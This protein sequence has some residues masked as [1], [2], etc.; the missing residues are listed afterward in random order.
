MGGASIEI[1]ERET[2]STLAAES[3]P[4]F[5][6]QSEWAGR[7]NPNQVFPCLFM[8]LPPRA[9]PKRLSLYRKNLTHWRE[10][11]RSADETL[12]VLGL[13]LLAGVISTTFAADE[14]EQQQKVPRAR[15]RITFPLSLSANANPVFH[16]FS[17]YSQRSMIASNTI[18]IPK[19]KVHIVKEKAYIGWLNNQSLFCRRIAVSSCDAASDTIGK[20]SSGDILQHKPISGRQRGAGNHKVGAA[21]C[22]TCNNIFLDKRWSSRHKQSCKWKGEQ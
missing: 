20:T 4:I 3:G 22:S 17:V 12:A 15:S 21:D 8:L 19:N 2:E 13:G 14:Q 10:R 9:R 1:K 16:R 11:T 5:H 7:I 6:A 18:S